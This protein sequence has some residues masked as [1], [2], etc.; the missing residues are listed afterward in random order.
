MG[1]TPDNL[2]IVKEINQE[3]HAGLLELTAHYVEHCMH[4]HGSLLCRFYAHFDYR[5]KHYVCMN[6]LLPHPRA[7]YSA[8]YDLKG[9]A[10][11]KT[12]L[13]D[14]SRI[15]E[16]HKRIFKVHM[17]L[18]RAAWSKD[19]TRYYENKVAAR[20]DRFHVSPVQHEGLVR[21]LGRDCAFLGRHSLMDYSLIV[22]IRLK[23]PEKIDHPDHI[24]TCKT[25]METLSVWRGHLQVM[26]VGIIDFLQAWTWKKK[27]A[28]RVKS[29]E[30]NKATIPPVPYSQRFLETFTQKF[31]PDAEPWDDHFGGG[32]GGPA[33]EAA[34]RQRLERFYVVR[35]PD[36]IGDVDDL[37]RRYGHKEEAL[38]QKLV[39]KYGA[40]PTDEAVAAAEAK[41]EEAKGV[42]AEATK[43]AA[44]VGF[45]VDEDPDAVDEDPPDPADPEDLDMSRTGRTFT[46][47]STAS[48]I[49]A[50]S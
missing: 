28:M 5:N 29:L 42:L 46:G 7:Q 18:G 14:G 22:G 37:V 25:A 48:G 24:G 47:S 33:Q 12:L 30:F 43:K 15:K 50:P 17:W 8:Q 40:E 16:V 13:R 49:A 27:V 44:S 41:R 39:A 34:L 31:L 26:S 36:K 10:D 4:R 32:A 2:F 20:S 19:R 11:D 6:N 23:D 21:M 45:T 35:N 38:F 3:D 1:F 9:C